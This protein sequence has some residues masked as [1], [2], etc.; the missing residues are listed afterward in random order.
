MEEVKA[1]AVQEMLDERSYQ[2][3]INYMIP[4]RASPRAVSL[5]SVI[6]DGSTIDSHLPY[7]GDARSVPYGGGKGLTFKEDIQSYTDKG[8]EKGCRT[9]LI[10]VKNEE[11]TY[12]YTLEVFENGDAAIHVSSQNRDNISYRGAL[13][14]DYKKDEAE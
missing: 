5:Y 1:R 8:W 2:I 13:D 14:L 6:V 3:D 10:N 9:I 11:D 12:V 4:L 7:I